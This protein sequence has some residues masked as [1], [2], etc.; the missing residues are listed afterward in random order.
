MK[1]RIADFRKKAN[2]SQRKLAELTGKSFRTIQKWESGETFPPTDDLCTLCDLFNT[3][4]NT[5][6]G[7]YDDHPEDMPAAALTRGESAMLSDY[8]ECTPEGRRKVEG[9]ARDQ[10]VVSESLRQDGEPSPAL[11]RGM[12]PIDLDSIREDA[13]A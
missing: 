13:T 12:R 8:R 3:D 6:V 11:K 1:M 7:W 9:Y 2:I 10:R 4:P 5:M